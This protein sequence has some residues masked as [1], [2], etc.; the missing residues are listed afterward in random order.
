MERVS[1]SGR[2]QPEVS[3]TRFTARSGAG[4]VVL[5]AGEPVAVAG[6]GPGAELIGV[7]VRG[8]QLDQ[9]R[10]GAS[11]TAICPVL[12]HVH[13]VIDVALLGQ[14]PGAAALVPTA[15]LYGM[16]GV[17]KT[18]LALAYAQPP[19]GLIPAVDPGDGAPRASRWAR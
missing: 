8:Q 16:G 7:A 4:R 9:L 5:V 2:R 1:G 19:L 18:Q 6:V 12:E 13:G 3:L 14:L 15:A 17:G 10:G 11:V